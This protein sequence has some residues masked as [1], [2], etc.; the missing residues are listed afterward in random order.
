MLHD[1][2]AEAVGFD[3]LSLADN[4]FR[5]ASCA[6]V[7]AGLSSNSRGL[8]LRHLDL[9]G[10]DIDEKG[11][12]AIASYLMQHN[13]RSH[14]A[15]ILYACMY[16]NNLWLPVRCARSI[17]RPAGLHNRATPHGSWLQSVLWL[18][19][20]NNPL[21]P[22]GVKALASVLVENANLL[23]L[24]LSGTNVGG[25]GAQALGACVHAC[26]RGGSGWLERAFND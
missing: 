6:R 17:N 18:S 4:G 11:S 24:D 16:E 20:A 9:S 21:G 12:D 10:N 14:P 19:L 22:A 3:W 26:M 1:V 5:D 13:V 7:M 23:H 8:T 2:F 25:D 15:A